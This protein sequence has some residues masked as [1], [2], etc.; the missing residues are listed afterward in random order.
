M[1]VV[2]VLALL[3]AGCAPRST[4]DSIKR[5]LSREYGWSIGQGYT[6]YIDAPNAQSTE[7]ELAQLIAP[8]LGKFYA[9]ADTDLRFVVMRAGQNGTFVPCCKFNVT[10]A[11]IGDFPDE[12]LWQHVSNLE[13]L[14]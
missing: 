3:L 12:D 7:T 10:R 5:Y 14:K 4:E 9:H 11:Q 2:C 13:W 8:K 6:V 1:L